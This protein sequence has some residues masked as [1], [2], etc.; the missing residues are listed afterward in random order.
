MGKTNS[1]GASRTLDE[2][3]IGTS[4]Q[5]AIICANLFETELRRCKERPKRNFIFKD[6]FEMVKRAPLNAT[7]YDFHFGLRRLQIISVHV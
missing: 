1:V 2:R 7:L 3:I 6:D 4:R 5:E